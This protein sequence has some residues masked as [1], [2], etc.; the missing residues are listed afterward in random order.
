MGFYAAR[1]LFLTR[2]ISRPIL[3]R[4]QS[5]LTPNF[6]VEPPVFPLRCNPLPQASCPGT[7]DPA[8]PSDSAAPSRVAIRIPRRNFLAR[9]RK[10]SF[11]LGIRHRRPS[12]Q[13]RRPGLRRHPRRLP[14]TGPV[15]PRR[16]RDPHRH[17]PRR[18]RRRNHHPRLR[19]L[20]GAGPRRRL[21]H[22]L[23]QRRLRLR[24]QHLRRHL[25]H[26]QAVRR[27]RHGR[28]HRR[29]RRPGHDVR[30]CHQR[31][32]RADAH[33]HL[34]GPQ[35]HSPLSEVRKNGKLPYL[36]PDGKSQVTVEYDATTSPSASTPSSSPP[37]TPRPSPTKS[38]APTS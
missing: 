3:R 29:R 25:H 37:S 1:P 7:I 4:R 11:Y 14:R 31:D 5:P 8:I 32:A 15:Q 34:A 9:N 2:R 13:D 21:R 18:H 6:T 22:R 20:P 16:L 10:V 35:A 30:L 12:R 28:R 36:R 38:S 26:Q 24:L 17:R 33:A 19:R 23:R 27:H